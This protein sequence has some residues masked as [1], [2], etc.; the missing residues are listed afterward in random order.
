MSELLR[1]TFC[2]Y[3]TLLQRCVNEERIQWRGS[4]AHDVINSEWATPVWTSPSRLWWWSC[5]QRVELW[6]MVKLLPWIH[7]ECHPG[8][9]LR[10][11]S[12][13][14]SHHFAELQFMMA[15]VLPI[16]CLSQE[17][18]KYFIFS[19]EAINLDHK[20]YNDKY[21]FGFPLTKASKTVVQRQKRKGT[22]MSIIDNYI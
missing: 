12:S 14:L 10:N 17:T 16:K 1:Y 7:S 2:I 6:S 9:R 13:T 19:Q 15:N 22:I 20:H 8:H 11:F 18:S 21:I 4:S 5:D 3:L